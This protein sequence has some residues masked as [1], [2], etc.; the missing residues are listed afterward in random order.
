MWRSRWTEMMSVLFWFA[1]F[2]VVALAVI[3][4]ASV[5][6]AFRMWRIRRQERKSWH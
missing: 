1:L 2:V 3:G 5:S 4:S 6:G